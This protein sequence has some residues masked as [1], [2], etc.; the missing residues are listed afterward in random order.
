MLTV[1]LADDDLAGFCGHAEKGGDPHPDKGS[2]TAADDGGCDAADIARADGVGQ[3]RAGRAEAGNRSLSL[4][5]GADLAVGVFEVEDDLAL[6]AECKADTQHNAD[7]H[8]EDGH[9]G[10]PEKVIDHI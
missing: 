7:A 5:L 1:A 2:R 9:P 6:V 8:K 10:P 4:A 3:S